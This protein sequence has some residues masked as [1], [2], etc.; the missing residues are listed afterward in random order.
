MDALTAYIL[1]WSPLYVAQ[2]S[3]SSERSPVPMTSPPF[4][5]ANEED[6]AANLYT[7]DLTT[8]EAALVGKIHDSYFRKNTKAMEKKKGRKGL[9][10]KMDGTFFLRVKIF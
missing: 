2:P 6:E 3:A 10:L 4:W 8:G 7:V 1:M 9:R 5:F